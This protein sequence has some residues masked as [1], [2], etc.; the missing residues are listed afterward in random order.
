LLAPAGDA[1][2]GSTAQADVVKNF[3]SDPKHKVLGEEISFKDGDTGQVRRYD[4]VVQNVETGEISGIE[5]KNSPTASYG[6]EQRTF[7][8][9]VNSG[10]HNIAPTGKKAKD[11][12]IKKIDN[13][14]VI[15]CK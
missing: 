4:I 10:D 6:S 3:E 7:D 1:A 15:R 13:V 5:V 2:P 8:N 9:K 11:A 12:K 14:K